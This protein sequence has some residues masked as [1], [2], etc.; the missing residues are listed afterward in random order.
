VYETI[1]LVKRDSE[2]SRGSHGHVALAE[3]V[4]ATPRAV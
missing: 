1:F 4:A 3:H 2:S